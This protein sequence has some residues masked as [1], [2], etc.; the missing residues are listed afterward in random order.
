MY[1]INQWFLDKLIDQTPNS[2]LNGTMCLKNCF[3]DSDIASETEKAVLVPV[4]FENVNKHEEFTKATWVPKSCIEEIPEDEIEFGRHIKILEHIKNNNHPYGL[5][6]DRRSVILLF[7]IAGEDYTSVCHN[8]YI[9][10]PPNTIEKIPDTVSEYLTLMEENKTK[11]WNMLRS[12]LKTPIPDDVEQCSSMTEASQIDRF[13]MATTLDA[14]MQNDTPIDLS[15]QKI[16]GYE[17]SWVY[18]RADYI[19]YN[20]QIMIGI[21]DNGQKFVHDIVSLI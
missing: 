13:D 16:I 20:A 15:G 12:Q 5:L 8:A 2:I 10:M 4:T 21:T 1:Q 17:S 3:N 7:R 14:I 9:D 18:V 19:I 11:V 6:G